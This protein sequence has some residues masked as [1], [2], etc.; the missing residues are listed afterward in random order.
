M[1]P[2]RLNL[3]GRVELYSPPGAS[4]MLASRKSVALLALLALH[5]ARTVRRERL[6]AVLWE[7]ASEQQARASLRQALASLRRELGGTDQVLGSGDALR[8]PAGVVQTDVA[9]FEAASASTDRASLERAAELYRGALMEGFSPRAPAFEEWLGIER[10]RLHERAIRTLSTL[11]DRNFEN[12]ATQAA[13]ETA[14]RL[15]ALDPLQERAHRMLMRLYVRQ[16]RIS[17]ALQHFGV[18]RGLLA[19]DLGVPP[20]PETTALYREIRERR[21]A[22]TESSAPLSPASAPEPVGEEQPVPRPP[23]HWPTQSTAAVAPR[24][25]AER[26]YITVLVCRGATIAAAD[27]EDAREAALTWHRR[28]T[29]IVQTHGGYVASAAKNHV[30]A[31]FGYPKASEMAP[32]ESIWAA[33][34]LVGDTGLSPLGTPAPR[35]GIA[36]GDIIVDGDAEANTSGIAVG[37][38]LNVAEALVG[39]AQPGTILASDETQHLVGGLFNTTRLVLEGEPLGKGAAAWRIDGVAPALTRFQALRGGFGTGFVGRNRELALLLDQWAAARVDEGRTVLVSGEPGI[40]KSRLIEELKREIADQPHG[41]L[42]FQCSPLH[43]DSAF[44]PVVEELRRSAGIRSDTPLGEA[45]DRVRTLLEGRAGASE[46][47]VRALVDLLSPLPPDLSESPLSPEARRSLIIGALLAQAEGGALRQPL[48]VVV[49]DIQWIDPSTREFLATLAG[50][51]DRRSVLM[52]LTARAGT[53][54][55]WLRELGATVL[56]LG[57]LPRTPAAAII[58]EMSGAQ[59]LSPEMIQDILERSDGIPF[60]LE[61]LTRM[62]LSSG[63]G[64]AAPSIRSDLPGSLRQLLTAR[65]DSLRDAKSAAQIGSVIGRS[66]DLDLLEAISGQDRSVLVRALERLEQA[67][68]VRREGPGPDALYTFR[69]ALM[70]EAAYHSLLRGRRRAY[71]RMVAELLSQRSKVVEPGILARHH[72]EAGNRAAAVELLHRAAERAAERSANVEAIAIFRQALALLQALPEDRSRNERELALLKGL[73][74]ALMAVDGWNSPDVGATYVRATAL[75]REVGCEADLFVSIWGSWLH[76]LSRSEQGRAT[77]LVEEMFALA[78]RSRRA[79]LRLQ[80]LHA[81]WTTATEGGDFASGLRH[82][83]MGTALYRPEMHHSLALAYGGHDP[84]MCAL[85][86]Q[87]ETLWMLGRPDEALRRSRAA[88]T[89]ARQTGHASSIAIALR[90]EARIHHLRGDLAA[91]AA[92]AEELVAFAEEHRLVFPAASGRSLREWARADDPDAAGHA[93]RLQESL[94]TFYA[95]RGFFLA[96]HLTVLVR[97]LGRAGNAEE[98]VR[99]ATSGLED[100]GRTGERFFEPELLRAKGDLL[101]ATDKAQAEALLRRALETARAQGA[102]SLELRA[103]TSLARLLLEDARAEEA[104]RVLSPVLG[105][106]EEGHDIRDLIE[107]RETLAR[108]A[109]TAAALSRER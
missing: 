44:H 98:G 57:R 10:Q 61:E 18:V 67:G 37:E 25:A 19:R 105:R 11:L 17:A 51:I 21:G 79:D 92:T 5:P 55:A 83:E 46:E 103:A 12:G 48:L 34:T 49:E 41:E 71:H 65:L 15:L 27:P 7:D 96:E 104:H 102:L 13:T 16:G 85:A 88:V 89:L 40:G 75:A 91:L 99:M 84:G 20:E 87:G 3:L 62:V 36:T 53:E 26:R 95:A 82:A 39:A 60:F 8:L 101:L 77:D 63:Q 58:V 23:E 90:F 43:L 33:K 109:G 22:P 93:R 108:S 50:R 32:E 2:W 81:A 31:Y 86:H 6:L 14:L 106:F 47:Q 74:P 94:G 45:I 24:E 4:V 72:A 78:E 66:F 54:G 35:V 97:A 69:H 1:G 9:E 29:E 64:E 68:I 38:A 52:L 73:G 30:L 56:G 70:Q 76:A 107:A 28:A 80:A 42:L 59:V 100:M